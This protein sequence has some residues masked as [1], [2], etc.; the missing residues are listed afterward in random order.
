MAG[1]NDLAGKWTYR[2]FHND[3]APVGR[4]PAKALLLIFAEAEFTFEV[5]SDTELR[6]VID[7]GSG[8][9]DLKGTIRPAT[10]TTPLGVEIAGL[11]RPGP[12]ST[13]RD[14]E[15]DYNAHFAYQWPD[16]IN[17]VSAL[18]GTVIRA[19]PHGN[20]PAGYV[21]SFVAVKKS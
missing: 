12:D 21:A 10:A 14:W 13:T 7:W 16:G 18:A 6:G 19:K 2:S 11:G 3:P 20:S 1:S 4:D 17:Q 5:V 15:Y 9:L 8:G